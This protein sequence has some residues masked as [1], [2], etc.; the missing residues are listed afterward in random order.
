MGGMGLCIRSDMQCTNAEMIYDIPAVT[1][2]T[3]LGN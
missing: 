3:Q 1:P 2:P